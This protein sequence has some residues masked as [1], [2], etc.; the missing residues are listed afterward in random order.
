MG[1]WDNGVDMRQVYCLSRTAS[2]EAS[3]SNGNGSM[4]VVWDPRSF[5]FFSLVLRLYG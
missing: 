4:C 1:Q 3:E 2:P 5:I